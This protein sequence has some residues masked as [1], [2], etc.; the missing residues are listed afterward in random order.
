MNKQ[1]MLYVWLLITSLF[2]VGC[3]TP[4][5][6]DGIVD[7]CKLTKPPKEAHT[8]ELVHVGN[9][10]IYPDPKKTPSN[11]SGCVKGWIGDSSQKANTILVLSTKF[12][13]G[14]VSHIDLFDT[15]GAIALVC[16]FDNNEK[17]IKETLVKKNYE[18]CTEVLP[19]IRELVNSKGL[20]E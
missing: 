5:N 9:I 7:A 11:Y 20:L 15:D 3:A 13:G 17:L 12:N 14:L 6:T 2:M 8:G 18:D 4:R 16:E 19:S 10:F 1:K